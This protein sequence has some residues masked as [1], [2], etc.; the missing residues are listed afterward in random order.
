[1]AERIGE[2]RFNYDLMQVEILLEDGWNPIIDL[3]QALHPIA[4]AKAAAL[5]CEA[6]AEQQRASKLMQ[7]LERENHMLRCERDAWRKLY[8]RAA[9]MNAMRSPDPVHERFHGSI[10][11]VLA[12]K[13][14]PEARRQM[15]KALASAPKE[16]APFPVSGSKDDPRRVG[17]RV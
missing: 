12:G 8:E 11:D 7:T 13:V 6:Q 10:G 9:N 14:I 1:M 15:E 17:W 2:E 16:K 5:F 4:P 3:R